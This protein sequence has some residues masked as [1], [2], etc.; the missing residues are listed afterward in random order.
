[1]SEYRITQVSGQPPREYYNEKFS[2]TT[3]YIKV[4]LEGH[5]R[6][7]SIGKKSPDA[8]KAGDTVYGNIVP[9]DPSK[10]DADNFKAERPAER[11]QEGSG[12]RGYQPRDDMA[13][14]AQWAI[15]QAVQTIAYLSP[16]AQDEW[17]AT[18]ER[19]AKEFYAMVDRV[20]NSS[21]I[22]QKSVKK[23][24]KPDEVVADFDEEAPINLDDIPF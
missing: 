14:R 24:F 9:T 23:V 18:V 21:P 12:S 8:L 6:P 2:S 5:D 4:K 20:K 10:F 7:V 15:G 17:T 1:M 22:T 19:R 16:K 11:P 13:I 3:Y